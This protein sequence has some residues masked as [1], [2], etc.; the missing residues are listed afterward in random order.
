MFPLGVCNMLPFKKQKKSSSSDEESILA[1]QSIFSLQDGILRNKE[2]EVVANSELKIDVIEC[3][4]FFAKANDIL[5]ILDDWNNHYHSHIQEI[6]FYNDSKKIFT[7]WSD[8][9]RDIVKRLSYQPENVQDGLDHSFEMFL[10]SDNH[11]ELQ[12]IALCEWQYVSSEKDSEKYE[13]KK[14]YHIFE[15]IVAPWNLL[16]RCEKDEL[17]DLKKPAKIGKSGIGTTLLASIVD[18][19]N[20]LEAKS[21]TV[22][23]GYLGS[24]VADFY[25]KRMFI[26]VD[27][28]SKFE[29]L[30]SKYQSFLEM[31]QPPHR[32]ENKMNFKMK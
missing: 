27:E 26:R 14:S 5:S 18:H 4:N 12:G 16:L 31:Y 22:V 7:D 3:N 23:A 32:I 29:L 8:I 19:A 21:I 11:N 24:N 13:Q 25:K 15:I 30:N 20:I 1:K 17:D 10:L 2:Q 6:L 28:Y 9:Y